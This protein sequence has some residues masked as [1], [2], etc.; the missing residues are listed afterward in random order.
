MCTTDTFECTQLPAHSSIRMIFAFAAPSFFPQTNENPSTHPS[1]GRNNLKLYDRPIFPTF[2]F[3]KTIQNVCPVSKK[4]STRD[5]Q[6]SSHCSMLH[7]H[8]YP[9]NSILTHPFL[10]PHHCHHPRPP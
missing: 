1:R 5:H 10:H 7:L 8:L 3:D 2:P 4:P 6:T 9:S